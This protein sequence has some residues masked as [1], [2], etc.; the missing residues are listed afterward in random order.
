M[1]KTVS[2]TISSSIIAREGS[3]STRRTVSITLPC[4][5]T[6]YTWSRAR[7]RTERAWRIHMEERF[8]VTGALGCIGAWVVRNLARQGVPV[9][10]FDL[11]SDPHRLR[12]IMAD[13]ELARVR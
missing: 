11:A 10:V 12:L 6:R 13:D 5:V 1:G 4:A 9:T 8:L 7:P 2:L 3:T